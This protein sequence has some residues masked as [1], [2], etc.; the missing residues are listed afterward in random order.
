MRMYCY[1]Y[2]NKLFV[3]RD[4]VN[5][6]DAT[7]FKKVIRPTYCLHPLNLIWVYVQKDTHTLFLCAIRMYSGIRP[8]HVVC[9][10]S[11]DSFRLL[12]YC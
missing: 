8:L 12:F 5:D 2:S 3:F 9:S 1:G 10:I 11:Y 7:L 6:I 4:I